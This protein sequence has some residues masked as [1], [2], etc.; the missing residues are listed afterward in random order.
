MIKIKV[1]GVRGLSPKAS[2]KGRI[3]LCVSFECDSLSEELGR[4]KIGSAAFFFLCA[5]TV[6]CDVLVLL[7]LD[8]QLSCDYVLLPALGFN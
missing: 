4:K 5:N 1:Q 8:L 6:S 2:F 7:W 3:P